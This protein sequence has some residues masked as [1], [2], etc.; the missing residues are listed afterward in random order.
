M[1]CLNIR[2]YLAHTE[3][4]FI[5]QQIPEDSWITNAIRLISN[6]P[7]L[8]ASGLL[9][10]DDEDDATDDAMEWCAPFVVCRSRPVAVRD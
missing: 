9:S 4:G 8:R 5:D 3:Q 2:R 6:N 7:E 1:I 10:S